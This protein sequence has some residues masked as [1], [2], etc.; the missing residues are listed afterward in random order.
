M[1]LRTQNFPATE[2]IA[3]EGTNSSRS[4]CWRSATRVLS[5]RCRSR[6]SFSLAVTGL[7]PESLAVCGV[8]AAGA[9][10]GTGVRVAAI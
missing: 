9:R 10:T 5:P 4:R 7:A 2:R 3:V 1:S 8:H 6:K